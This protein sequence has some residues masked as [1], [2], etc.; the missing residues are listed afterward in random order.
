[1]I[2]V[3]G[4]ITTHPEHFEEVLQLSR[5]HVERSRV[6]PGCLAHD[7]HRD[8]ENPLRLV[9]VEQWSDMAALQAHFRVPGTREFA[10][11]LVT[12]ASE[13]PGLQLFDAKLAPGSVSAA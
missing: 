4:H 1:M 7:V 3:L 2:L 8:T 11:A 13:P 12:M 10:K 6:E 5:Q 9:F